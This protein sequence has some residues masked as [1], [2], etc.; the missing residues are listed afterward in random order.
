MSNGIWVVLV[1]GKLRPGI[2]GAF[3][4]KEA[5]NECLYQCIRISPDHLAVID[6]V[7]LENELTSEQVKNVIKYA[8][9]EEDD[10]YD[11]YDGEEDEQ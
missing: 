5:A 6:Y 1:D 9:I 3:S 10:E 4:S 11:V 2:V 8:D 7:E